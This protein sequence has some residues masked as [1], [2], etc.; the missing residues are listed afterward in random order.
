[1]GAAATFTR[2]SETKVAMEIW[3]QGSNGSFVFLFIL[4]KLNQQFGVTSTEV[5]VV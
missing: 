3:G 1:M 2:N 4:T 5:V